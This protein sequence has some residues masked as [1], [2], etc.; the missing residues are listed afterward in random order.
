VIHAGCKPDKV[1]TLIEKS[2]E[3]IVA[4]FVKD[5]EPFFPR[6]GESMEH[7]EVFRWRDAVVR[8]PPGYFRGLHEF[9]NSFRPSRI[10]L[11]GDYLGGP[12]IEGAVTA[13]IDAATQLWAKLQS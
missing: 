7:T 11:S 2:D 4:A 5:L 3:E 6:L 13:G 9:R 8:V 10:W 12:S 1:D